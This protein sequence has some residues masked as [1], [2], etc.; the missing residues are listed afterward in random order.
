MA[1]YNRSAQQLPPICIGTSVRL[2]DRPTKRWN[3]DGTVVRIGRHRDYRVK[4]PSVRIF[5]GN[6]R[7][8]RLL[9]EQQQQQEDPGETD[10]FPAR[11]DVSTHQEKTYSSPR[12]EVAEQERGGTRII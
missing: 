12:H 10:L 2:Q 1:Y 11:K 5:W 4:L 6:H 3:T 9:P 7:F 8:I